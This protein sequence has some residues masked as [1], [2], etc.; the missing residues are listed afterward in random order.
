MSKQSDA[1][2]AQGYGKKP[3]SCGN[4][5]NLKSEMVNFLPTRYWPNGRTLEKNLRC[6]IGGFAVGKSGHCTLWARAAQANSTIAGG[7]A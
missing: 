1:K 6:G 3:A 2:A 7:V 4:C 5:V